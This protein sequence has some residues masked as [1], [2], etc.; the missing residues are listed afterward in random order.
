MVNTLKMGFPRLFTV[1]LLKRSFYPLVRFPPTRSDAI[2]IVLKL[3]FEGFCKVSGLGNAEIDRRTGS[4]QNKNSFIP[5][6]CQNDPLEAVS[7]T[8][9]TPITACVLHHLTGEK[10]ASLSHRTDLTCSLHS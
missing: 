3:A 10:Q 5:K 9:D 4:D 1:V 2:L 6:L 7:E 8:Y